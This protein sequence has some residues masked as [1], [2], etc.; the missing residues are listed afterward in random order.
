M[1]PSTSLLTAFLCAT[2]GATV[3]ACR[4][5]PAVAPLPSLD[6]EAEADGGTNGGSESDSSSTPTGPGQHAPAD[7]APPAGADT[8]VTDPRPLAP[9]FT[10][11][12]I[13]RGVAAG[14]DTTRTVPLPGVTA[15]LYRVKLADGT[16]IEPAV[17]VGTAVADRLSE[18]TFSNVVSAHYRIDVKG[19]AGGPFADASVTV[20][21][22]KASSIAIYVLLRRKG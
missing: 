16:P 22:P 10:L 12:G 5:A 4:E 2:L 14:S 19:P 6:T 13:I 8:A 3:L 15:S 7:P 9:S 18:V 21:P 1:R 20:A 17:L 11:V